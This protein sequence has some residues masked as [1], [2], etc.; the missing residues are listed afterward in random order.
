MMSDRPGLHPR[1]IPG[2]SQPHVRADATRI[3]SLMHLSGTSRGFTT[4]AVV[5]G[6]GNVTF[7]GRMQGRDLPSQIVVPEP[8]VNLSMLII[9]S[10]SGQ[11]C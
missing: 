1:P 9:A 8:A 3:R 7:L 5:A 4:V 2:S 10:A 6:K 11:R